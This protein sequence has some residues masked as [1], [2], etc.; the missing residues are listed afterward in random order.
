[1]SP[2]TEAGSTLSATGRFRFVS[3]ARRPH[4]ARTN[5]GHHFIGADAHPRAQ[6]HTAAIIAA[7]LVG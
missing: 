5:L 7:A 4:A 2:A 3:V 1:V 6:R